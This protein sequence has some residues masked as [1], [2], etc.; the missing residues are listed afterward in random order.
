MT[1]RC[2][3]TC[4][5]CGERDKKYLGISGAERLLRCELFPRAS[6]SAVLAESSKKERE[7]LLD[8]LGRPTDGDW[9]CGG[10]EGRSPPDAPPRRVWGV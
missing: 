10:W 3:E 6:Y 1:E 8:A 4:H 9:C 7:Y 5:W 2:C